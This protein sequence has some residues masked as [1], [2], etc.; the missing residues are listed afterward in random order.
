MYWVV[1]GFRWAL[2]GEGNP[3]ELLMLV[4]VTFVALLLVSGAFVFRRTE[5]TIVDLL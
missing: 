3:P 5:R 4:P 1:E 2:L